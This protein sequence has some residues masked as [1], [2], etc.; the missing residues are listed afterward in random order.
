MNTNDNS[1]ETTK[2]S[3]RNRGIYL[4][5]NALTTAAMFAGFYSIIAAVGERY[6]AASIAVLV[7]ALLDGLDGRVARATN[8]QSE[9]GLHYDSMS[10]LISFGVAPAILMYSWSLQYLRD[11]GAA[12]GKFGWLAAFVFTAC[13]AMRLAR[14]N[15]QAKSF[16]KHYFQGLASPAAAATLVCT[17][18]FCVQQEFSPAKLAWLMAAI[19]IVLGVL[20]FSQF[21]YLSFKSMPGSQQ[22]SQG[23]AFVLLLII[24]LLA[25]NP[26]LVLMIV[27]VLYVL[28]GIVITLR[29]RQ[30]RRNRRNQS[31]DDT[32]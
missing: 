10:D 9:F 4:L 21:R 12:A 1:S 6:V 15:A 2:I 13:A 23:W 32:L 3:L 17:V 5:P 25:L 29:G 14:Y 31:T 11:F 27:G 28:S 22:R 16:D 26:P 8:S 18:W 7:A 24:V 20:M 30:Q 19:T